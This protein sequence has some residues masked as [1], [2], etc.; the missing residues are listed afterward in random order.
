[1]AAAQVPS[2]AIVGTP[3]HTFHKVKADSL[4]GLRPC[5]TAITTGP[6]AVRAL[7]ALLRNT[8]E[9]MAK[10]AQQP[11]VAAGGTQVVKTNACRQQNSKATGQWIGERM[12]ME[13]I[14]SRAF[15]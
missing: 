15:S 9:V 13:K 1:M 3:S 12:V 4:A 7:C 14:K 2:A 6:T 5:L 11:S 8:G 10:A